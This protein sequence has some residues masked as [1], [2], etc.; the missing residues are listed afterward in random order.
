MYL[1]VVRAGKESELNIKDRI[2]IARRTAYSPINTGFHGTNGLN[3]KPSCAIYRAYVL[4]GLLYG[5]EVINITK[6][7]LQ[8][9]EKYHLNTLRHIQSLPKRI[10]SSA[11][12]MLLGVLPLEA[13]LH[14][15][16][17]SLY[18]VSFIHCFSSTE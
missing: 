9:L 13:E 18:T 17:L 16:Q 11:V 1:G 7:K 15:R 14:K 6:I 5:S 4:P 3:R 12:Y 10:A 2:S 8:Q